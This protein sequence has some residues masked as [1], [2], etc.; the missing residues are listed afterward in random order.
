MATKINK[1]GI[2]LNLFTQ[3]FEVSSLSFWIDLQNRIE[4]NIKGI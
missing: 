1:Q 4:Q 2:V 3:V